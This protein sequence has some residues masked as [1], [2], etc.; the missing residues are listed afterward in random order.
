[1]PWLGN[2]EIDM[3]IRGQKNI[4][5]T[6]LFIGFMCLVMV[7]LTA[8]AAELRVDNNKLISSNNTLQGEIDTL[9]V[10]IKAANNI[11]NIENIAKNQLGMVYPETGQYVYISNKDTPLGD[12][13]LRIRA[14]AYH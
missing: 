5:A 9:S 2:G 8:Y 13:A 12:L 3:Q 11:E 10:R 6:I 14:N 7:V 1:M 4:I